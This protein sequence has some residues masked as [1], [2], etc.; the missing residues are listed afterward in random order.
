MKNSKIIIQATLAVSAGMLFTACSSMHHERASYETSSYTSDY[1]RA[2][3]QSGIREGSGAQNYSSWQSSQDRNE[4][5]IPLHEEQLSVGKR[6][7]DAGQ[8][9]IRKVVTT[10]T[11]SQP[12]QLRRETLIIDREGSGAQQSSATSSTSR[13]ENWQRGANEQQSGAEVSASAQAGSSGASASIQNS[14]ANEPA[15]A[16]SNISEDES[17]SSYSASQSSSGKSASASANANL[18][19]GSGAAFQ[20]Q[21][22]TIRLQKEEPV[23]QKNIVQTGQV[24]ARKNSQTQQQNIQQQ[25]RKEDVQVD[26][27]GAAAQNVEIRGNF[28]T[29]G[30]EISEPSGAEQRES[31][32]YKS[33][34]QQSESIDKDSSGAQRPDAGVNESTD[35]TTGRAPTKGQGAQDLKQQPEQSEQS[36][37]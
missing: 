36:P 29:A 4:V 24:V 1:D 13:D 21:T 37:Q 20:E 26:K 10:E 16:S 14:T 2:A 11:V 5:I 8:V 19:S 17:R 25:V 9:T 30:K 33:E 35:S 12:V 28:N 18:D 22:Y 31:L 23:I 3:G 32:D 7:V 15:G 27:S 34:Q 6:T